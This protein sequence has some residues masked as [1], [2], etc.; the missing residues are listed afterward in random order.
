MGYFVKNRQLQSGSTGVVLPTGTSTNRPDNP[1]FGTI[2]YNTT[3]PA[4]EYFDGT[5]WLYLLSSS[6]SIYTVD[7]F[8]RRCQLV[9]L[10]EWYPHFLQH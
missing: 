5:Q 4:V 9:E 3:V 6:G 8:R 7:N 1:F 2:R 10:G